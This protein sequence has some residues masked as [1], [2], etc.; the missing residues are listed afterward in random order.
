MPHILLQESSGSL[1][2]IKPIAVTSAI[3]SAHPAAFEHGTP[4]LFFPYYRFCVVP[5]S[6]ALTAPA[7]TLDD[8]DIVR[9]ALGG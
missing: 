6:K 8:S 4:S 3:R 1:E 5:E 9:F 7:V 2:L